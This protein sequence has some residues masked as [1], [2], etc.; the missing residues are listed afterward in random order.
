[1]N[2]RNR[3][4]FQPDV[5]V[6][7]ALNGLLLL[8]LGSAYIQLGI[9]NLVANLAIATAK[10]GLVALYFMQLRSERAIIRLAAAAGLLWLLFLFILTFADVL[11]RGPRP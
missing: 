7:I 9:G 10:A 8:T 4:R 2:A 5:P 6:W 11:T 3:K 1:M